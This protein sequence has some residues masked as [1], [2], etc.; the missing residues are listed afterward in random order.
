MIITSDEELKIGTVVRRLYHHNDIT[1]NTIHPFFVI[2]KAT[3]DEWLKELASDPYARN[4]NGG[5]RYFYEVS[6]D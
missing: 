4:Y 6:T 2:R 1:E 3:Q 5:M